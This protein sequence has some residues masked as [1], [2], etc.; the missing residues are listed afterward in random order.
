MRDVSTERK[1]TATVSVGY[2]RWSLRLAGA[3]CAGRM[4]TEKR[5]LKARLEIGDRTSTLEKHGL[6]MLDDLK[7]RIAGIHLRNGFGAEQD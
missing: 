1:H 5:R 4:N 6:E 3:I 2:E 7:I